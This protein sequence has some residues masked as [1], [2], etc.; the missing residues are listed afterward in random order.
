MS[1]I[2]LQEKKF[3][4][5]GNPI[6]HSQSPRIHQ[7]FS[8][9]TGIMQDYKAI[10]VPVE[11]ILD[12]I[13]DFFINY[14][15]GANIT[16]PFKEKI[17]TCCNTLTKR[18]EISGSVNTLKKLK[19]NN[20]LGDNTDGIGIVND[21]QRLNFIKIH[22]K[23]LL[24]G[25]GGAAK[26]IIEPLLSLKCSI[27]ITNRTMSKA[28]NIVERFSYIG[29][30]SSIDANELKNKSFN[31]IINATSSGINNLYPDLPHVMI[32]PYTNCYDMSYQ[33]T[34]TPFLAWCKSKGAINI[35]NGIGML[36]SQAAYS[37][38]LW[39]GVLPSI[40]KVINILQLEKN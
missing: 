31:L 26:G 12:V 9:H 36:V 14:G 17:I 38:L 25:A 18:A 34:I 28:E 24:I 5:F 4:V 6:N 15:Q 7:L 1:L 37:F 30:I 13:F 3:A 8:Y 29:N 27:F 23:I 20:L 19:K 39:H 11:K 21:L 10:C 32:N 33:S 2:K 35:A 40:N 22:D 16:L